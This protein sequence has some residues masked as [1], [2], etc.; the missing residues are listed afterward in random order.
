MVFDRLK[1]VFEENIGNEILGEA[2]VPE[3]ER[4][5]PKV[6][7]KQ[8]VAKPPRQRIDVIDEDESTWEKLPKESKQPK[9]QKELQLVP[10]K[11]KSMANAPTKKKTYPVLEVF[12]IKRTIDL[13]DFISPEA[14]EDVEFTLTAPTGIN[15]D[16]VEHFVDYV[17]AEVI[18]LRAALVERQESFERILEEHAIIEQKLIDKQQESELTS[19]IVNTKSNEEKLR[20]Q[21]VNLRLENQELKNRLERAGGS[22]HNIAN[23]QDRPSTN[24]DNI[25]PSL[26]DL[27]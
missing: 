3:M 9:Q 20:E 13:N 6:Q 1:N 4:P 21:L 16:E 10:K 22:L 18:K 5:K 7:P 14:I 12:K 15:P 25:L 23:K 26:D 11:N 8:K 17:L 27:L 19:L 2:D 24:F